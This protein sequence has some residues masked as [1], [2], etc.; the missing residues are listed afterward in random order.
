MK[1]IIK[2]T[3]AF[4][5]AIAMLS[6]CSSDEL[7]SALDSTNVDASTNIKNEPGE[8]FAKILARSLNDKDMHSF[9]LETAFNQFD[10]DNNFLII[11]NLDSKPATKSSNTKLTFREMLSKN[12]NALTKSSGAIN[13]DELL[14]K[15]EKEFPLQQIY[16][17]NE[18]VW[19][20]TLRSPLVVYL[21]NDFDEKNTLWVKGYDTK[22][23]VY[24]LNAQD[25][26]EE[27]PIIVVSQNERTVSVSKE[28]VDADGKYKGASPIYQ[29][30]NYNYY[31]LE[32]IEYPIVSNSIEIPLKDEMEVLLSS[33]LITKA[34][35]QCYRALHTYQ[36]DYINRVRITN[37][38]A[39]KSIEAAL[40]GD[41]ELYVNIVYGAKSKGNRQITS[42][43]KYVG[44]GYGRRRK[45]KWATKD[46]DII[47]WS[48][49]DNGE[50]MKYIWG[51]K[52][53]RDDN[54][55]TVNFTVEF[56]G[57]PIVTG[58][59]EIHVWKNDDKAGESI[60]YYEDGNDTYYN[61]GIVR[62]NIQVK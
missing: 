33:K 59:A 47:R 14:I 39:W 32:D 50:S 9:I 43:Y 12:S 53:G 13:L 10:G 1:Q 40:K 56:L 21:P 54:G 5:M 42:M 4:A 18:E 61:T 26:F 2:L 37:K 38:S 62:Y 49:N 20:T 52:D 25:D 30:N 46:I 57:Y 23:N 28:K 16:V 15:I 3:I 8:E 36:K 41:P 55:I 35:T 29:N 48:R 6:S 11:P 58:G 27:E 44:T 24:Q 34:N 22:G 7:D 19:D 45:I 31:L 60:V 51:E 17:M